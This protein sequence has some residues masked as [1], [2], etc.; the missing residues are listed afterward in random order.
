MSTAKVIGINTDLEQLEVD[1][2]LGYR[3][4]PF[5][6]AFPKMRGELFQELVEDIRKNGLRESIVC[7]IDSKGNKVVVDGRNRLRACPAAGVK[8]TF[9]CD[10]VGLTD[11]ELLAYVW[12]KNVHRRHLST[13][14]RAIIASEQT[15]FIAAI[16]KAKRAAKRSNLKRGATKSAKKSR[17][18][19]SAP[20]GSTAEIVAKTA[21]VSPRTMKDAFTVKKSGD[22]KLVEEVKAGRKSVKAAAKE[23]RVKRRL[24]RKTKP[25]STDHLP[26]MDAK[27]VTHPPR[28]PPPKKTPEQAAKELIEIRGRKWCLD[29]V[30]ALDVQLSI[31]RGG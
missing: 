5:A 6:A 12:S 29:L 10:L 28:K 22:E 31:S 9:G 4:H 2:D 19:T 27:G 18:G 13:S 7:T 14:Q 16:T 8:P 30:T 20:S 3:V 15:D 26:R 24:T 17:K 23:V 21:K 11:E 25:R 1:K